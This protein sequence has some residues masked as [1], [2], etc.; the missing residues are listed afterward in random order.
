MDRNNKKIGIQQNISQNNT[1]YNFQFDIIVSYNANPMISIKY[2]F[3]ITRYKKPSTISNK[4]Q[5]EK[6]IWFFGFSA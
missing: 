5:I 3:F 4:N 6:F 2:T 1:V